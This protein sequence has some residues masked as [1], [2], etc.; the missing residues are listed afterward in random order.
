M[1]SN[2]QYELNLYKTALQVFDDMG[3]C[4]NMG[5]YIEYIKGNT[6]RYLET[7][8]TVHNLLEQKVKE[9]ENQLS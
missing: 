4:N 6:S 2:K 3:A 9:L 8:N 7:M 5:Q 1:G